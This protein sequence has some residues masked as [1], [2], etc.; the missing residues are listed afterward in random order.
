[1]LHGRF[2][3]KREQA[4]VLSHGKDA[5]QLEHVGDHG[6]RRLLSNNSAF[7]DPHRQRHLLSNNSAF[8]DPHG[9]SHVE[10]E[11]AGEATANTAQPAGI[12]DS[13]QEAGSMIDNHLKARAQM[14]GLLRIVGAQGLSRSVGEAEHEIGNEV[15]AAMIADNRSDSEDSHRAFDATFLFDDKKLQESGKLIWIKNRYENEAVQH[16]ENLSVTTVSMEKEEL[17]SSCHVASFINTWAMRFS[18]L[19]VDALGPEQLQAC[20]PLLLRLLGNSTYELYK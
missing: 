11:D 5:K 4:S 19:A 18:G 6:Q 16:Q 9:E 12:T 20:Q 17:P 10:G 7:D 15:V 14:L 8:D 3:L 13:T 1:L 2:Y